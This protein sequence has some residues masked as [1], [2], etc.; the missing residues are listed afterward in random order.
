MTHLPWGQVCSC[1]G[2]PFDTFYST[3]T[4]VIYDTQI[5]P[6]NGN[7]PQHARDINSIT[8]SYFKLK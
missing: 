3:R 4:V 8:V 1:I 7:F 6:E 5:I 2:A